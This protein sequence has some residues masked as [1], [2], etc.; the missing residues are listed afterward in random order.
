MR[1]RRVSRSARSR[2]QVRYGSWIVHDPGNDKGQLPL[3]SERTAVGCTEWIGIRICIHQNEKPKQERNPQ[4]Q[5]HQMHLRPN[6]SNGKLFTL[7]E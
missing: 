4:M 5:A 1:G 7:V 2:T 6:A 3:G